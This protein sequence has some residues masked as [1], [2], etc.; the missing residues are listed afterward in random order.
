MVG[1]HTQRYKTGAAEEKSR[2][3]EELGAYKG[4]SVV[5]CFVGSVY[6]VVVG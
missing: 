5:G 6:V 1:P 3:Q 2:Y 4:K